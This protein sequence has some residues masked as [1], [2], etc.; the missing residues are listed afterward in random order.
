VLT[1]PV[2]KSASYRS[3]PHPQRPRRITHYLKQ[4]LITLLAFV[5][6]ATLLNQI[7]PSPIIPPNLDFISP[8]YAY[9]QAHRD[10]YNVLFFG[11]SRIYNQIVPE[12]FDQVSQS[13]E[14][15]IKSFNF[16]IPAQRALPGYILLRDVLKTP[17]KNLKWVFI[18]TPL[19]KGYEPIQN[20]RTTRSIY[21]HTVPNTAIALDYILSSDESA[22]EKV[23]LVGSHV[24]PFLYHH[25]NLGRLLN[26]WLPIHRFSP[27]DTAMY[28]QVLSQAGY[29]PLTNETAPTRQDFLAN[30]TQYEQTVDDLA[31]VKAQSAKPIAHVEQNQRQLLQ[32]LIDAVTAT[33]AE[34]IFIIP[35]TLEPQLELKQAHNSGQVPQLWAFNDPNRYPAL[36]A[37]EQRY[38]GEHL[39]DQGARLFTQMIAQTF[40]EHAGM[41]P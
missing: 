3:H 22:L 4:S 10:D 5:V 17:P 9:Y 41:T 13:A 30:L 36:Y 1:K 27:T 12:V 25:M 24:L 29:Y 38:D 35:P 34:P 8:K 19:D 2:H 26:Q 32:S 15:E 31:T 28:Q 6:A 16:G 23:A 40:T 33:G 14:I 11:S 20:A 39:N 21:W 7:I 18:E 37:L